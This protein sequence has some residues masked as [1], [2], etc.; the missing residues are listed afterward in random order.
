[1]KKLKL[2]ISFIL[3]VSL[4]LG[5][6]ACTPDEESKA[7][8]SEADVSESVSDEVSEEESE[9]EIIEVAG[10]FETP[11]DF[12]HYMEEYFTL[13]PPFPDDEEKSFTFLLDGFREGYPYHTEN[14]DFLKLD[15]KREDGRELKVVLIGLAKKDEFDA[16]FA[17]RYPDFKPSHNPYQN[18]TYE[19]WMGWIIR[20]TRVFKEFA[21][22]RLSEFEKVNPLP[23]ENCYTD[24]DKVFHFI[25]GAI[26]EG[27]YYTLRILVYANE[28]E[29][30][31]LLDLPMVIAVGTV[32][33]LST[34]FC[35]K[36]EWGCQLQSV[37]IG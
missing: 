29:L 1:M 15:A 35:F 6:V 13:E 32:S 4:F 5:V 25:G 24:I 26:G 11:A 12:I 8:V 33:P 14:R 34:V 2:I 27:Y 21:K 9:E 31:E 23:K 17:K 30:D 36:N 22:I 37:P 19:V 7:D 20:N 10:D 28:S 16:A 3:L 18:D